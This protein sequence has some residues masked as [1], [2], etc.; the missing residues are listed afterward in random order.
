MNRAEDPNDDDVEIDRVRGGGQDG[1]KN[2]E[3]KQKLEHYLCVIVC[4]FQ[5]GFDFYFREFW[6]LRPHSRPMKSF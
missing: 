2:L 6:M 4:Q 1:A 3:I 5:V